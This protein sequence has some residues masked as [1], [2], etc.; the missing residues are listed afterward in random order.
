MTSRAIIEAAERLFAKHG[1]DGVSMRQISQA[2]G[3]SNHFSVQYHFGD[4]KA[5]AEGIIASRMADLERR[6][7]EL[8]A[9]AVANGTLD[10][11]H[12]LMRAL[13]LP[14][15]YQTDVNGEHSYAAFAIHLYWH[16]T[17]PKTWV[18]AEEFAPMVRHILM[19]IKQRLDLPEEIAE[20]RIRVAIVSFL[21]VVVDQD[22]SRSNVQGY[23]AEQ[24]W[25]DAV[26]F[27]ASGV[28]APWQ[29]P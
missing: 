13:L 19:L 16:S 12:A 25:E 2:A 29:E 9:E 8:L 27:A 21:H 23:S 26:R 6:R 28:S 3:S 7:G 10:D 4:K 20:L 24:V 11:L 14:Y 5:L 18:T 15:C 17:I 1:I 22:R